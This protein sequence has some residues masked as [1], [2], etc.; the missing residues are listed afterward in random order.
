MVAPHRILALILLACTLPAQ[1]VKVRLA[2]KGIVPVDLEDYVAWVLAGEAGGMKSME[3]LKAM[4]ITIRTYA[5][6]NLRR[7]ASEGFDFCETTHCQDARPKTVTARLRDAVNQTAGAI[8]WSNNRPALVFYTGHCA[9]HTAA[10]SE[11]WPNARRAYLPSIDDSFCLS[12]GRNTWNA[13]L[14][15]QDLA[16]ALHL[17]GLHQIEVARRT[18]SG[19]ALTLQSN[20]GLIDAEKLHLAVGRWKGWNLLRSRSYEVR[21]EDQYALFNGQGT[22]H[23]VGLC[24]IGAEQRGKAG[25]PAAAILAAYFPGLQAGVTPQPIPWRI[26]QG[27]RVEVWT[28]GAPGD[29]SLAALADRA[30][31]EAEKRS[32][33]R[34]QKRPQVRAYPTVAL[35]RNVA[36]EPGNV[37]AVTRGRI[38]HLQPVA[39]L[40]AVSTLESTLLHEMLHSLIALNA[41]RPL[42][43]WFEEG[44]AD[45]LGNGRTHP[46]ERARVDALVK[47]KGI[48]AVISMAIRGMS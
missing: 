1:T 46:A 39:R 23:G 9:G 19:R 14:T 43:L 6:A 21:S 30:L 4:A 27:E 17:P 45:Y 48:A 18:A 41:Q 35:F 22:G 2:D 26:M 10:A 24:Q 32:T 37:A 33:L 28:T 40:R 5:R 47:Q 25:H 34:T 3:A 20:V 44:L 38:I 13:K 29:E 11:I 8:L 42:P 12:A 31:I 7:H 36:G 15:W 16:E